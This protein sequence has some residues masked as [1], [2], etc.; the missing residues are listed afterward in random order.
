MKGDSLRANDINVLKLTLHDRLVGY[1][2][3]FQGG[4]NVL[5][6]A[7]E[8]R[9]DPNRPT[10]SLITT[11]AFPNATN[12]MDELWVKTQRLHPALSNLLPEGERIHDHVTGG[13]G[14]C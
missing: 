2:A 4:R 9:N 8:F 13:D 1:L 10:F 11:P 12:V 3:G 14:W 7:D 6:F 5:S